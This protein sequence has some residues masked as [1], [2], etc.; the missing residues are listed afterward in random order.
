ML[1]YTIHADLFADPLPPPPLFTKTQI[2]N[3]ITYRMNS[4]FDININETMALV[5]VVWTLHDVLYFTI[6]YCTTLYY[7]MLCY[8]M[9]Y[10][11]ILDE[12]CYTSSATV[13]HSLGSP[14]E[15]F[16]HA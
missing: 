3:N 12:L 9:L 2:S 16:A 5:I 1:C 7:A 13:R 10:Y 8:A 4:C 14:P 6:L 11:T 15:A